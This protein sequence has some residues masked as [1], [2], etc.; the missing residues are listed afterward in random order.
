MVRRFGIEAYY[1]N[2]AHLEVLDAAR[3]GE[4]KILVLAIDDIEASLRCAEMVR[5][6]FPQVQIVARARDR[7]HAYRLMDLGIQLQMREAFKSSLVMARMTFEAL[8]KPPAVARQIVDRFAAHDEALLKREQA[9]YHDE[10]QLIQS[11]REAH[12][13][14]AALLEQELATAVAADDSGAALKEA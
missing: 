6:H 9:L 8:G 7:F 13:E 3:V 11:A 2:A 14:L 1:G 10:S 5:K 4:A 12:E